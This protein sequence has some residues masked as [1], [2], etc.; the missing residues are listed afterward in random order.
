ME[1]FKDIAVKIRC[2]HV[3]YS[4]KIFLFLGYGPTGPQG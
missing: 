1:A 2:R 3:D 4:H